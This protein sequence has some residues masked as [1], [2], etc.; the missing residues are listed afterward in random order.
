MV[1][2]RLVAAFCMA[3]ALGIAGSGAALNA[4]DT[5]ES[6]AGHEFR[7]DPTHSVVLF[8]VRNRDVSNVHGRFNKVS[9]TI[10][11]NSVDV[12]SNLE[13]DVE[14]AAAT[15]DTNNDKRDEHITSSDF[16]NAS[17][18]PAITFKSTSCTKIEG[19]RFKLEGTL[20]L[21]GVKRELSTE[22]H[23]LNIRQIGPRKILGGECTFSVK[24]SEFGMDKMLDS[25]ADEVFLTVN[26][27]A[28]MTP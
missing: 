23:L 28:A 7:I 1:R 12:P 17:R 25:I 4:S 22:F 19:R 26:L 13:F 14:V 9:G 8:K 20:T 15:I 11:A 16:L 18:F 2:T 21:L 6:N 10:T 27:E 5:D 3:L 24:R